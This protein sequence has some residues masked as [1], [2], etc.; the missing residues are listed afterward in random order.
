V[1][2][3][4][5]TACFAAAFVLAPRHGLLAARRARRRSTGQAA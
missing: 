2:V 4:L 5:Q 1:I 3:L